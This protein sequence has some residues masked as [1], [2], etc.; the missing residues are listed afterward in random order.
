MQRWIGVLC[1]AAAVGMSVPAEA[2]PPKFRGNPDDGFAE[3]DKKFTLRFYDAVTGKP[4]P[5]ATVTFEGNEGR[6]NQEGA[7]RFSFPDDLPPGEEKREGRFQ[8]KGYVTARVP[9]LFQVGTIFFN[10][11]SVS[12]MIPIGYVRVVLDWAK[13]PRDLDA[14]L[15]KRGGYHISFR[16]T[17]NYRER[18]WLDRDDTNGFGPETIT[19]KKISSK[20]TYRF[21]VHNW[22]DKRKKS[23]TT[24]SDSKARISVYTRKGLKQSFTIPRSAAGT[25]WHVFDIDKGRIV[26]VN[27]VKRAM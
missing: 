21:F 10:R 5:G 22:T 4:I 1:L 17:K 12:P 24:L 26:P 27:R 23:S 3:L 11:F 13:T 16:K 15:K 7:V 2:A 8:R 6:T 18:A 20:G 19:V 9:I 14:H 25:W